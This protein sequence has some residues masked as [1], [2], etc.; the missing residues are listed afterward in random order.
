MSRP[1]DEAQYR[2][3]LEGLEVTV[4][5]L[6]KLFEDNIAFRIDSEFNLKSYLA[7][8]EQLRKLKT[9]R[10]GD[11]KPIII[12]PYEIEREYVEKEGVWFFRAQNLR[13]LEISE[14]D[15]V[16]ISA[17]D[18][19][20]LARNQ[21]QV[22]DVILTRTGANAGDCALF[23]SD[24]FVIASSHTFII[25]S[26]IWP[27]PFLVAFLNSY[28]G[29][30]QIMKGRYGAAQPEIAPNYLR[31]IWIPNFSTD[32]YAVIGYIFANA[33]EQRGMALTQLAAAEQT[34]LQ[35]LGLENWQPPEPLTY[36][37]SSRDAFAAGRLDAEYFSPRVAELLNLLNRDGLTIGDVAPARHKRFTA[38]SSGNFDYIE[39]SGVRQDGTAIS[40]T[41]SHAEAPS[42][43]TWLVKAGDVITS[44]V[45]PIRRLSALIAPEQDG[46]VCSSGFVVL[47]PKLI[48][49][50]VLLAYLR[51]YPFCGLMD[52]YTSASLY[53]AISEQDLLNL[54][55]PRIEQDIQQAIV[56]AV[57][58]AQADRRRATELL[59]AAKRAVEIAIESSEAAALEFLNAATE[60]GL[61][62]T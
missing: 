9:E 30:S 24:E 16:F 10:F 33:K 42:R 62:S 49:R 14:N 8:I 61:A 55:I 28:Y 37:R 31:N 48:P 13:P 36:S 38:S 17:T 54:P 56:S 43:A 23:D 47:Q 20:I 51:F 50:E 4:L 15:K 1:F 32:F 11:S 5:P 22:N 41:V 27:H 52:L 21:L 44:T 45:R 34:L 7:I 60:G 46:F 35:A 40:E 6:S 39:I 26:Q 25:R 3:L 19:A 2:A 18:A 58:S 29:R 57:Q 59:D 12:H 53:P